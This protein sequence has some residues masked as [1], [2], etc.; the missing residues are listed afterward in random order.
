MW[1]S[2]PSPRSEMQSPRSPERATPLRFRSPF[3]GPRGYSVMLLLMPVILTEEANRS[4]VSRVRPV[5]LP[6]L[7]TGE[8]TL[9]SSRSTSR[10]CEASWHPVRTGS[11]SFWN[12]KIRL[13]NCPPLH[14]LSVT[15]SLPTMK[16][17]VLWLRVAFSARRP[18][19]TPRT[20][21]PQLSTGLYGST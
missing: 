11:S 20:P 15:F 12:V 17:G 7:L 10:S 4:V 6:R 19:R 2:P 18:Y 1:A 8:G 14:L 9:N 5:G 3:R 16:W 13:R 21:A